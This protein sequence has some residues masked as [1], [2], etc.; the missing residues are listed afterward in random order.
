MPRF[1]ICKICGKEKL[2][3]AKGLCKNCYTTQHHKNRGKHYPSELKNKKCP[4]CGEPVSRFRG[5]K[6]I[7]C[8]SEECRGNFFKDNP[9]FKW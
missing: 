8:G 4:Y 1:I 6:A 7:T 9:D 3:C 5:I 2:N